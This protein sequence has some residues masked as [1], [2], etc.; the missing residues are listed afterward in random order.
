[1]T[2]GTHNGKFH[3]DEALACFFLKSIPEFSN[4]EIVRSRN[5]EILKKID[6]LV[7]VG[8]VYNHEK[9]RY[10]HHQKT[11][12]ETM[13]SLKVLPS[14]NTKLSSAGLIYAHY[15]KRIISEILNISPNDSSMDDLFYFMY[16][17]FVESVD[18]IDNGV[19][20]YDCP[21]KYIVPESLSS[22]VNDLMPYWNST[23]S[24]DE[25][26]LYE[27]FMKAIKLVGTS[28]TNKLES[29]YYSWLPAKNIVKEALE[30]RFLVHSTGQIIYLDKGSVPWKSQLLILEK[31]L[32][33]NEK[34]ISF[35][36][37]KD[38]INNRYK[39]QAIP[40]KNE[41]MAFE[42][43]ALLKKEWRGLDR[44]KLKELSKINDI[45]FVHVSGFI[46]GANSLE[47]VIEM[48][49]RSLN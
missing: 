2:I 23:K 37:Y 9:R 43:R 29:T 45:E 3:T 38:E 46:G 48:A 6:I 19:N 8:G 44:E 33:L 16:L 1:M 14:F 25:D 27:Q 30:K 36:V 13:A 28:F 47:S 24:N 32:C 17:F 12:E 10:D 7:D 26:Y 41:D 15:G 31:E 42:N 21:P 5:M 40:L 34:D 39:V 35:V 18:A 49:V 11:F 20:C 4:A 22:R